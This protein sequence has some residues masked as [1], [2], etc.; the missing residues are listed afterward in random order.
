MRI[1]MNR[2]PGLEKKEY[3]IVSAVDRLVCGYF[4]GD[5]QE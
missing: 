3:L 2:E 5:S 1:L 4:G